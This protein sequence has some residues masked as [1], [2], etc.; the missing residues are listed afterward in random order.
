MDRIAML[1]EI[2]QQNPTEPLARYS[3]A[4]EFSNS[5][6]I[7]EA[8]REFDSLL[9][10]HSEYT[11]G[12]FMAAQTLARAA[13]REEARN[14]LTAGIACAERTGNQHAKAEMEAMLEELG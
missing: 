8:L 12:Y 1:Q 7:E 6:R 3:L 5:G 2:L 9:K 11:P 10:L 4:L 14:M 13:R